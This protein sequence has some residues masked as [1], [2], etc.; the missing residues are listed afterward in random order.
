MKI[1]TEGHKEWLNTL[2]VGDRVAVFQLCPEKM[3]Y[4]DTVAKITPT[5]RIELSKGSTF[6]PT[7]WI[8]GANAPCYRDR[9]I[10]PYK[11]IQP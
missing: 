2:K 10:R 9:H 5:R 7:G 6:H 1:G 11:E 8:R 3:V 4:Q